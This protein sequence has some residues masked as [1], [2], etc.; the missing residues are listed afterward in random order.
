MIEDKIGFYILAFITI[1][2]LAEWVHRKWPH[3]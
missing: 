1:S 2:V 3:P